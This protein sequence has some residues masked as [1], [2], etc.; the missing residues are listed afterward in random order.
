[1]EIPEIGLGCGNLLQASLPQLI[2]VA[3][4]SGFRRITARPYTFAAA[5]ADGC[6]EGALR[7]QLSVAGIEVT[8][9]DALTHVL[10]GVPPPESLDPATRAVMP[11]DVL[12]PPTEEVVFRAAEALG[13]SIV[14]LTHY[15]G[16]PVPIEQLA[17]AVAGICRRARE[18]GLTIALEFIPDTGLPSLPVTQAVIE[19]CGEP[20]CGLTLDVFHLDRS[21]GTVEDVRRLPSGAIAGLQ[22][23]DRTPPP[24]GSAHVPFQDRRL[25]GEG[26]LPLYELVGAALENSP[27]ATLDIEVLNAE[28]SSLPVD[29]AA[30]RL[31][32]G[33][34]SWLAT[35]AAGN[36]WEVPCE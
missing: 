9:I 6:T 27:G 8:M 28:L 26:R 29:E 20:N 32:A 10:P 1:M 5:L 12:H 33:A 36:T 3:T 25:P 7:Q 4:K 19:S 22:I 34:R 31:A 35:F 15:L 24:P 21:D 11:P 17:E 18:R 2:D 30:A 14:N 16:V 23:S 13:A